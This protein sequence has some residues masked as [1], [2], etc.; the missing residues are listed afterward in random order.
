MAESRSASQASDRGVERDARPRI[1]EL[2]ALRGFAICGIMLVNTWQHTRGALP[3]A[4]DTPV[5]QAI[6][7]LFE[8]RFYPIFSFLFGVGFVLFLDGARARTA[9][10]RLA[11]LA[12]LIVLACFGAL[13]QLVNPGEVLLP[14]AAFGIALLLP[15]SYLPAWVSLLAGLAGVAAA[16]RIDNAW[17]LIAAL[18][19]LGMAVV[20]Y[21]PSP[22][23]LLP[24]FAVSAVAGAAATW[25]WADMDRHPENWLSFDTLPV[26]MP[27]L[28]AT[29]T[30]VAYGTGVMLLARASR[31]VSAAL[32]P[33]GRMAL[34][35]Y[36]SSTLLIL[37]ALP[38]LTADDSRWSVVFFSLA[39]LA[40]Q[41]VLSHGWLRTHRYG[42]LEW[43]WRVLTWQRITP[44][45]VD[46]PGDRGTPP[47]TAS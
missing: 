2:D 34:T 41:A 19:P 1:H 27:M 6:D 5:D 32:E 38:F 16:I 25:V 42:P 35:N 14:Y 17:L 39:V 3:G 37:V 23:L 30:A 15:A 33:L 8:G 11:L 31:T 10:P 21:R 29:T 4:A 28:A 9:H 43:V 47:G 22:R 12:R 18:F 26:M 20:R 46:V 7:L 40:V 45:R 44:N 36:L 24:A 13:H